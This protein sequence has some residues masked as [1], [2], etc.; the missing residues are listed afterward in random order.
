VQALTVPDG[1][2]TTSKIADGSVTQGK[3][4]LDHGL[5]M[6]GNLQVN[7]NLMLVPG[8]KRILFSDP[9]NYDFSI[10]H[11]GG[12]SLD[13]RL[14]EF[15]GGEVTAL[16]IHNGG[17]VSVSGGDLYVNGQISSS[18]NVLLRYA[19]VTTDGDGR[20]SI[21][22]YLAVLKP[23]HFWM[24]CISGEQYWNDDYDFS[25]NPTV[26]QLSGLFPNCKVVVYY[27][28]YPGGQGNPVSSPPNW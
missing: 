10:V 17:N 20:A 24:Q 23:A 21:G 6:S 26:G 2:I 18:T 28:S 11:N 15:P 7:G 19:T 8:S 14:P 9:G 22:A 12:S 5:E 3:L 27:V 4:Q 13:F 1:S 25:Y 16:R